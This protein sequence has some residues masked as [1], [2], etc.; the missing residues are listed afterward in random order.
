MEIDLPEVVGHKSF[1]DNLRLGEGM[2][3]PQTEVSR[4]LGGLLI[5]AAT[6]L[7]LSIW[8]YR[9]RRIRNRVAPL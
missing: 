3:D 2:R 1:I 5:V 4:E 6:L 9:R 8:A 7:P